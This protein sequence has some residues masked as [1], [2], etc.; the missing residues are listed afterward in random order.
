MS[1]ETSPCGTVWVTHLSAGA[2]WEDISA[3]KTPARRTTARV[4]APERAFPRI[5]GE[6]CLRSLTV[7]GF[8][9]L[10]LERARVPHEVAPAE[11][12][13]HM[14]L[15]ALVDAGLSIDDRGIGSPKPILHHR[16]FTIP[17]TPI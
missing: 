11:K 9:S 14:W 16:G 6:R 1:V 12:L 8:S 17:R 15:D 4:H 7:V 10:M 3:H 13:R 2:A 5:A